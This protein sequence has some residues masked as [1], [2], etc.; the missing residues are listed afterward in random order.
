MF[1][2]AGHG[3]SGSG[4]CGREIWFAFMDH[5]EAGYPDTSCIDAL[6]PPTFA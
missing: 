3:A 2:H 6:K 4:D 5:P 1:P